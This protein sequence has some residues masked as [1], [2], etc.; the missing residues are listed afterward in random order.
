[1]SAERTHGRTLT[2]F[3]NTRAK[4]RLL[5]AGCINGTVCAGTDVVH[6][7]M[8]ECPPVDAELWYF[9]S[10]DPNGADLDT[11][12]EHPGARAFRQ[13][14]AD[15][16]PRITI[17]FRTGGPRPL[18]RGGERARRYAR[19]TKLPYFREKPRGLALPG[20]DHV[21]I[22]LP[23]GRASMR[24]AARLANGSTGSPGPASPRAPTRPAGG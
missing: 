12:R 10:L 7:A 5:I 18:V 13:A 22:E 9:P 8:I 11:A 3:G 15:L 19:S 14:A 23:F 21:V 4:S 6:A 1:M 17:V 24:M 16:R 2:M 20:V